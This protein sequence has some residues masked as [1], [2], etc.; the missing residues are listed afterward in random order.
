MSPPLR[1]KGNEEALWRGLVGNDLQVVSTDHCPFFFKTQKI[2]GKGDFSKIPNGAPGIETRMMLLW[3]GGVNTGRISPNRFV[4]LTSTAPAKIFGLFPRKGTIAPGSD[5]DILVF[6]PR[7]KV[8]LSAKTLHQRVDYTPY[9]GRVV[10][11]A[12]EVVISRGE[13]L[14]QKGKGNFRKGRG[15][16]LRRNPR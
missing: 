3:D 10:T 6:D 14:V 15:S 5:A 12:P 9:E 11:G 8:T 4:E 13:V 1:P 2:M 16:F 7:K